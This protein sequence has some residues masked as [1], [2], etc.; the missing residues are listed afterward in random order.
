MVGQTSPTVRSPLFPGVMTGDSRFL[1]S[2]LGM[3]RSRGKGAKKV[4]DRQVA[5]CFS[6][7]MA[8]NDRNL[9]IQG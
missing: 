6:Q 8:K 7:W 5:V 2:K 1:F 3:D 9:A 4:L